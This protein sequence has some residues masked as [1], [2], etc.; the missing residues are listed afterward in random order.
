MKAKG[1]SRATC[2]LTLLALLGPLL[3]LQTSGDSVSLPFH[4]AS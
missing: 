1:T 3:L 4:L 2:L